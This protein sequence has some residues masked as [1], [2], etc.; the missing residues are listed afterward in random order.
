MLGEDIAAHLPELRAHAES[1]MQDT[2]RVTSAGAPVWN[3]TTGTYAPGTASTV[4][5]GKCRLRKP[6]AAPQGVESGEAAWTVDDYV[7]SLPLVGSEDV[8]GGHDVEI[9]TALDPAAVGLLLTV[10]G[11]HWQTHSTARRIPCRVVA[12]DA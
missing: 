1:L 9:V 4:Y 2:C 10:T 6:S 5:E 3:D 12:R 7:L 11:G 8:A